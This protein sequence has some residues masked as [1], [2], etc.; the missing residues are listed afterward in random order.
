[1]STNS[2]G[3]I[4]RSMLPTRAIFINS[5]ECISVNN[6]RQRSSL[7]FVL[8]STN[9]Y[10]TKSNPSKFITLFQAATKSFTNFSLASLLAY[11]SAMAQA[12]SRFSIC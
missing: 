4:K 5:G 11:T 8:T 9:F 10:F 7:P 1:V 6:E 12:A 2:T 3:C